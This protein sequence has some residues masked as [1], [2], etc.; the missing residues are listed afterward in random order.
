MAVV[1][2]AATF[3]HVRLG[4]LDALGLRHPALTQAERDGVGDG[5]LGEQRVPPRVSAWQR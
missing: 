2:A 5:K 1:I 3:R 4:N